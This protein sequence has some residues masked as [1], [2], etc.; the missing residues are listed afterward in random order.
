MLNKHGINYYEKENGQMFCK[1]SSAGIIKMLME[2]C[3][4]SGAQI[5]LNCRIEKIK[6][7]EEHCFI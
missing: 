6:L 2:E 3:N 7:I 1:N 5:L 4:K